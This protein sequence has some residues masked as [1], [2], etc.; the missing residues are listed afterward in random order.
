M[1]PKTDYRGRRI[2]KLVYVCDS[3]EKTLNGHSLWW[4]KCDCGN[5]VALPT[6]TIARQQSC[7]C[8]RNRGKDHR[9]TLTTRNMPNG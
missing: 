8:L 4:A 3:G 6:T 1:P 9:K 2:G 7:G 5:M